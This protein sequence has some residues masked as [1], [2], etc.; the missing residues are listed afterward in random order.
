MNSV[1]TLVFLFLINFAFG[2]KAEKII[3][4]E[5]VNQYYD[6]IFPKLSQ[7]GRYISFKKNYE[8]NS[9]TLVVIDKKLPDSILFQK[10]KVLSYSVSFTKK[11]TLFMISGK[12]AELLH[13][14]NL[15]LQTWENSENGFYLK[16]ED[17]IVILQKD[18]LLIL[19]EEGNLKHK[20]DNVI[21]INEEG[22]KLHYI[23]QHADRYSIFEWKSN[24]SHHLYTSQHKNMKVIYAKD[25]ANIIFISKEKEAIG[26]LVYACRASGREYFLSNICNLQIYSAHVE[27][28]ANENYF[29]RIITKKETTQKNSVDIWYGNDNE[30]EKKAFGNN[31]YNY[32][33]WNPKSQK[34]EILNDQS[35]TSNA[36]IGN[37]KYLLSFNPFEGKD[38]TSQKTPFVLYRYDILN[39]SY[40]IIGKTS[41]IIYTD[42]NGKYI[43]YP[44]NQYWELVN[45][46]TKEFRKIPV[47]SSRRACFNENSDL[48]LFEGVNEI[49]EYDI[50]RSKAKVLKLPSGFRAEFTNATLRN[51]SPGLK[52]FQSGLPTDNFLMIKL[53][54][55]ENNKN[56]L[57]YYNGRKLNMIIE[58]IIDYI[59]AIT[60]TSRMNTVGYVK[61]NL[62][63]PPR[64]LVNTSNSKKIVFNSNKMDTEISE[65]KSSLISYQNSKGI[66]LKGILIY[67]INYQ[68]NKKYPMIIS[69]YEK[70]RYLSNIYLVDGMTGPAEGINIRYF[71]KKD[72][73]IYLPDIVYDERGTGKSALDCVESSLKALRNIVAIDFDKIGLIGH[74]HGGYETNFIATKSSM[75]AAYVAGAANSDLVRSYHSFNYNFN[76]PFFWQFEDGQYRMPGPFASYKSIYIENSPVYYADNVTKPILL[77][78]GTKDYNIFWEQTMEFYLALRRNKKEVIA[79]FY[80]EDE[81]SLRKIENKIDLH[82][83]VSQWFDYHLKGDKKY[84]WISQ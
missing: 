34:V 77:W 5:F 64:L 3:P 33:L 23:I 45:I 53:Y 56:A 6:I 30:I 57:A 61:S 58:P 84:R 65:I 44:K 46:E 9:D 43:L 71:S 19:D 25:N 50:I 48:I 42:V 72:Y 79:L 12:S 31:E 4:K 16:D 15:K 28:M 74:S 47:Q 59:G 54:N 70:Q 49:V 38:F 7:D 67:P 10:S 81:H 41:F 8:R 13:L 17:Q 20:V 29:L 2:Q 21:S 11:N 27:E 75:F 40:E 32:L 82:R 80:Q 73:F 55:N 76:S 35:L 22:G 14:P 24:T 52:I 37:K 68:P 66:N 62:T 26:D 36:H 51:V 83:R 1:Y 69:V 39:R 78:A 60:F 63:Y 18:S